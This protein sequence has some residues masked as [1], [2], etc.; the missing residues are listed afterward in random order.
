MKTA[1]YKFKE[2]FEAWSESMNIAITVNQI[3]NQFKSVM[4]NDIKYGNPLY[5]FIGY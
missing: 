3:D 4:G 1:T 5:P 2:S